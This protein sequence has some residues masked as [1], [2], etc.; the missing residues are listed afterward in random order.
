MDI[1]PLYF[2]VVMGNTSS[3]SKPTQK[4]IENGAPPPPRME[5]DPKLK[6][7]VLNLGCCVEDRKKLDRG[8]VCTIS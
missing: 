7:N 5:W 3:K 6:R 8:C 4:R 1:M 2:S